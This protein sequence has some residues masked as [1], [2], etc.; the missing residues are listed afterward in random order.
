MNA[1]EAVKE[2]SRL[3]GS[4]RELAKRIGVMPP[5]VN[6]WCMGERPVPPR[7]AVQIE[8]ATAGAVR[9]E[10]LCPDFPWAEVALAS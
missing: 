9:R 7:R 5:T 4:Q 1:S 2:A 3:V 8:A 6:Q 10:S